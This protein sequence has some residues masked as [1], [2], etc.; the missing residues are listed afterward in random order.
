MPRDGAGNT[1]GMPLLVGTSGWQYPAW[2]GVL[3]PTDVPKRRWLEAYAESFAT[4]EINNAFYRLPPYETFAG[5]RER[6]PEDFVVGVKASRFL[7][8]VKRLREPEEPVGRLMSAAAGL[9]DQLG[10]VLLQ[11]PPNMRADPG[12]LAACLDSFPPG[13]RVAVEPRHASWWTDETRGV[14]RDRGAALC[15]ADRR[16]RPLTPLWCT[17]G[18]GYL[19]LHEGAARQWP[20]YGERALRSWIDRLT[21][22]WPDVADVY[23]FFNNDPGGAAV[24]DAA[25]F[26]ALARA[27][28]RR[29]SRAPRTGRR[30]AGNRAG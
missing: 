15:W 6:V 29:V 10:P 2:R 14:L 23:C 24:C 4:I 20:R 13:V 21:R 8:H 26:A 12:R 1:R 19:R 27:A 28:G 25:R 5:W 17:A 18:W 22:T 7:T 9:G 16:G 11:L 3:Y 30:G